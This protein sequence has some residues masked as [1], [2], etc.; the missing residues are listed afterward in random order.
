[1]RGDRASAHRLNRLSAPPSVVDP[2]RYRRAGLPAALMATRP[3]E[4]RGPAARD[5]THFRDHL[6]AS[7]QVRPLG[8]EDSRQPH[9]T[10]SNA[11]DP[12]TVAISAL[13]NLGR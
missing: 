4:L 1:M 2:T 12:S 3:P 13:I 6:N 8:R 9:E 7:S 5:R 11:V 10:L